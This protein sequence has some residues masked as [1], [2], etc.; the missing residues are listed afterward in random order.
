MSLLLL[1]DGAATPQSPGYHGTLYREESPVSAA[2]LAEWQRRLDAVV[3]PS[4]HLASLL[5]RWEPGDIWDPVQR[6]CLWELIPV[7][8]ETK[9]GRW[10]SCMPD[11][12]R[13]AL[14]GPDPRSTGHYDRKRKQWIGGPVIS[15][16]I[17]RQTWAIAQEFKR[18]TGQVRWA[19]RW[20]AVQGAEGGHPMTIPWQA[21]VAKKIMGEG[22]FQPPSIGDLDYAEPTDRMFEKVAAFDKLRK[23][24]MHGDWA[25]RNWN[26]LSR[27]E[28]AEAEMTAARVTDW[29]DGQVADIT[30][31]IQT[32]MA[33]R[34]TPRPEYTKPLNLPRLTEEN[35]AGDIRRM[36]TH[37][38]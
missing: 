29:W 5:I 22:A 36:F 19:M 24:R 1:P 28:Q 15:T 23:W 38:N 13:R 9:S 3:Q 12:I 11:P 16:G 4:D 14:E 8:H 21:K 26:D 7:E 34:S 37:D 17:D 18:K 25:F 6:F 32:I 10:E 2:Q 27:E 35:T 30:G 20:W 31:E 33:K